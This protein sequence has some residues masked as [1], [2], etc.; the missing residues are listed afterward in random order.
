[1]NLDPPVLADDY[2]DVLPARIRARVVADPTGCHLWTG[3]MSGR[4]LGA[5]F[6]QINGTYEYVHRAVW[7]LNGRPLA[8]HQ[9]VVRICRK[10]RCVRLDHLRATTASAWL[11]AIRHGLDLAA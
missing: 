7:R 11:L 9:I 4:T 10:P 5:G 2:L 1:V 8:P 6:A 3:G